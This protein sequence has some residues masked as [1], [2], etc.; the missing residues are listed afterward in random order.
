MNE[1]GRHRENC[2]SR[3]GA[4]RQP[5]RIV[6]ITPPYYQFLSA[7][8][9]IRHGQMQRSATRTPVERSRQVWKS[10]PAGENLSPGAGFQGP[11]CAG[12]G[13]RWSGQGFGWAVVVSKWSGGRFGSH[14]CCL[15]R[16][17]VLVEGGIGDDAGEAGFVRQI[18]ELLSP[19]PVTVSLLSDAPFFFVIF[20]AHV[21]FVTGHFFAAEADGFVVGLERVLELAAGAGGVAIDEVE[22]AAGV[23]EG[24]EGAA[25]GFGVLGVGCHLNGHDGS[26]EAFVALH[27]PGGGGDVEDELA[28]GV[29]LRPELAQPEDLELAEFFGGLVGQQHAARA[30]SVFGCVPGG[31]LFAFG[32]DGAVGAG[33]ISPGGFDLFVGGHSVPLS[34]PPYSREGG[35]RGVDFG[36][37]AEGRGDEVSEGDVTGSRWGHGL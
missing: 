6:S 26:L 8:A 17:F 22:A 5:V 35:R 36:E 7:A 37:V 19:V 27:A 34:L 12:P 2:R 13:S 4:A 25:G 10:L 9:G 20:V 31:L 3:R 33:A 15:R 29:G 14:G 32:G 11:L 1:T 24:E 21:D 18:V 23:G 16:L 28:L 30:E